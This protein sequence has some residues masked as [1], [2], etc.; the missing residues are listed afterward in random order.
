[1]VKPAATRQIEVY[2]DA[3]GRCW[4]EDWFDG[5]D[6]RTAAKVAT[7]VTRLE[8]GLG[9]LKSIGE[10]VTELRIN[11]GPGLR[12]YFGED[13]GTLVILLCGGTKRRQQKDISRA[14][15]LW[16][17]YRERKSRGS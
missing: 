13:A 1:M 5:L 9:D 17:E 11:W 7:A 10:G 15:L 6:A 12:V 14:K 4:F 2:E 8:R 3:G 16:S